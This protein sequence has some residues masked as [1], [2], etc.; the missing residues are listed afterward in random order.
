VNNAYILNFEL[1][2]LARS[3]IHALLRV[4]S[5]DRLSFSYYKINI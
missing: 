3:I 5:I 4:D 2:H 1:T